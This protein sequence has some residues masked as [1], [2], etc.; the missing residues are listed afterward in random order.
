M[1]K[2]SEFFDDLTARIN[3]NTELAKKRIEE[4]LDGYSFERRAFIEQGGTATYFP[5]TNIASNIS[6]GLM[7]GLDNLLPAFN[8]VR[9][10]DRH[11]VQVMIGDQAIDAYGII[12]NA[13]DFT[14]ISQLRRPAQPRSTHEI[15]QT[16]QDKRFTYLGDSVLLSLGDL[17]LN[18]EQGGSIAIVPSTQS[19]SLSNV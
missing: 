5:Y 1:N 4:A 16:F 8:F 7:S 17:A 3:Q 11:V 9:T 6:N 14:S 19:D 18:K 2:S 12:S 10:P 15:L 13:Y